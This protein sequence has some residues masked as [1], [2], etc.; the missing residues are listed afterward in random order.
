MELILDMTISATNRVVGFVYFTWLSLF[1]NVVETYSNKLENIFLLYIFLFSE[2]L[3]IFL[4]FLILYMCVYSVQM[5]STAIWKLG[6]YLGRSEHW[7]INNSSFIH[8][9]WLLIS[10]VI[11][12]IIKIWLISISYSTINL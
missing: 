1:I 2:S 11:E 10:S 8:H 4:F 7:L 12:N 5:N 9:I 6:I 3:L